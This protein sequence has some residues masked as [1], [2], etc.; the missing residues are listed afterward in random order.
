MGKK[1]Y[2]SKVDMN[3]KIPSLPGEEWRTVKIFGDDIFEISNLGRLKRKA[4]TFI[5]SDGRPCNQPESLVKCHYREIRGR[6]Y[7]YVTMCANGQTFHASIHSLVAKA[8]IPNPENKS[9]VNHIDGNKHNNCVENLEW[10]TRA[11]NMHH[12]R[13]NNLL[14]PPTGEKHFRS[15][16]VE[17]FDFN[18]NVKLATFESANIA[19]HFC[20]SNDGGGHILDVCNGKREYAFGYKWKFCD[21]ETVTTNKSDK[22]VV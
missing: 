8:F 2:K 14:K 22:R 11:E 5:K 9:E 15:I 10:V 1:Y 17:A 20:G 7:G 21:K 18:T 12:A 16:P 13:V 19:A 3:K 6:E 4:T